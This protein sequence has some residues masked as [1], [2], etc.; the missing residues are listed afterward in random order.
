[1]VGEAMQPFLVQPIAGCISDVPH[2]NP[3]KRGIRTGLGDQ[4]ANSFLR[5]AP[6][7]YT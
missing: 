2:A 1:M 6:S 3:A 5:K 7:H 4:M